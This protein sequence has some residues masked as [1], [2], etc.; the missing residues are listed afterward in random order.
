MY[1]DDFNAYF[2]FWRFLRITEE[3]L[4]YQADIGDLILCKSKRKTKKKQQRK[5]VS[6]VDKICIVLKLETDLSGTTE[7]FVLRVG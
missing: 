3:A 1:A 4:N 5:N 2:D 7:T 6:E